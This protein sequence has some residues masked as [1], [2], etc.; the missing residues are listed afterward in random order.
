MTGEILPL[1]RAKL[2]RIA[3]DTLLVNL[4]LI[5]AL[6]CRFMWTFARYSDHPGVDTKAIFWEYVLAYQHNA[7]PLTVICLAACWLSGFYT[8]G[9]VYQSRYKAL[10]VLGSI[11]QSYVLFAFLAYYFWNGLGLTHVPRA[12]L[13][14]A[15]GLNV[16]MMLVS[17]MWTVI[18]DRVVRPERDAALRLQNDKCR[19]VL[20]IGGAGYIG[21]ALL[22]KLL[23]AGHHVRILDLFL[24]GTEPIR[25][26]ADHP[27]LELVAGDFRHVEIVVQAMRDIDA[28][29]HLGALVGDPACDLDQDLTIDINLGATQMIAQVAKATGVRRFVFASTCSVYGA[30]DE[31]LDEWSEVK[32]IS[33]YGRTKLAAER[34]LQKMSDETFTPT[35]VRFSTI[36]GL[37][38]RTRF[39][40]V[41]NLLSAKAK[42]DGKITVH[43]GGQWRPFVHVDDAAL[44]V[45]HI[46]QAPLPAV[47]NEIFNVGSD[48]QNY[49]IEAIGEMIRQQVDGSEVVLNR[50]A[51]D[52]RNYR[53]SFAKIRRELG[54]E[55]NWTVEKGIRQVVDAVDNGQ[56]A[57]YLD[58]RYSN[59]KYLQDRG[60]IDVIR[61]DDDWSTELS[62]SETVRQVAS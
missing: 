27:N 46:L 59:A 56:V 29:V 15:A 7:L 19:R 41:I 62:A 21:S 3:A 5:F 11:L 54:F 16:G 31:V 10:A 23:R 39:D 4:A 13:V 60:L 50:D 47:A 37:S 52:R 14:L 17:R 2:V 20:V 53:V 57:N 58:A 26:V 25:E 9:R 28:V 45:F 38:G 8:Y 24:Y 44:A 51:A 12:A 48:H 32:P 61:V 1:T 6:V 36:Y 34:G 30:C 42:I 22:P 55:P 43:G 40:L 18:W 35:I 49:T 33:L